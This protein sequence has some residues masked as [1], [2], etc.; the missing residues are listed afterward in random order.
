M[1][2]NLCLDIFGPPTDD[3]A[4]AGLSAH[5]EGS[6][7]PYELSVRGDTLQAR[8]VF[9]LAQLE[10]ERQ[11]DLRERTLRIAEKVINTGPAERII[12]WTQHVT[13][14]P[15]FLDPGSARFR[16]SAGR[17]KVFE[18]RFGADDYLKAGAE[19]DWPLAPGVDGG[20]CDLRAMPNVARSS[21]YTAQLMDQ[22]RAAYFVAFSPA[23]ELAFGY[24]W[25]PGDFPWLGIWEENHS[26]QNPP[27]RGETLTRGLEFGVSPMPEDRDAMIRR[28]QLF[29]VPCGRRIGAGETVAAEYCVVALNPRAIPESLEWPA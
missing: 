4:E 24:V 9:P 15:P 29:G 7:V 16:A 21:A 6:V 1:G 2:H 12:G 25:R 27:W 18:G 17:S 23:F 26:R 19:F 20:V 3:E 11:I 22:T 28:G 8:A 5:G 10:F 13:L 14:G